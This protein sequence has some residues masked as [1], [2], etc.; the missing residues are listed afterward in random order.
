MTL[1]LESEPICS[2][3]AEPCPQGAMLLRVFAALEHHG[4]PYCVLHGYQEYPARVPSDVDLLIPAEIS[5][6]RLANVLHDSREFIGGRIVQWFDDSAIFIV[7]AADQQ[8]ASPP[9]LQ[10]HVSRHYSM[11]GRI[12]YRD[13]QII[14]LRQRHG[15]FY[16]PPPSIEFTCVLINRL[17]KNDLGEDRATRLSELFAQ[18]PSGCTAAVSEFVSHHSAD[19]ITKAARD[20]GW[21]PV[22]KAM[23]ILAREFLHSRE[24]TADAPLAAQWRR[25]R[26]WLRPRNGL[27]VVFLGPDGVGKST[28][29]ETFQRDMAQAFLHSTYLT[30][31]PSIIPSKLAPRKSKP[32]DLPPRSKPASLL[33]AAW[34]LL[35]YTVGYLASVHTV[36]ARGG[37]VVNHRYLLDAIVDRKRYRYSGPEKL[38][39]WIWAIAPKPNYVILLDAPAKVIA[40]RKSE[41]PIAEIARQREAYRSV[42]TPL[43]YGRVIDASQPL[44]KVIA[45][46]ERIALQY[47][48]D[49]CQEQLKLGGGR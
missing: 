14:S 25:L 7:L 49:R 45:D 13:E 46:A 35:C 37:L 21:T 9:M 24:T 33:K 30:F 29:I 8:E 48:A 47:L 17:C 20:E 31:A 1:M 11:G 28:V 23:P 44:E 5:A 10:L 43:P 27:H 22:R 32:H 3:P 6:Q 40:A 19:L 36:L 18:D 15:D 34:W 2:S 16:V 41:L 42:V 39:R 38:L 4:V 26:R 12:F